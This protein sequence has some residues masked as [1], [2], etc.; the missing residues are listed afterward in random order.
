MIACA[1]IIIAATNGTLD[2]CELNCTFTGSFM[3]YRTNKWENIAAVF[4]DCEAWAYTKLSCKP[5]DGLLGYK[6]ICDNFL[7]TNN[8][9]NITTK[10]ERHLMDLPYQ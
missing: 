10:E 5:R 8:V 2:H 3:I 9:D 4:Q 6:I 7:G 1:P